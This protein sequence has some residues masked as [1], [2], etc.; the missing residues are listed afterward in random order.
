MV[1]CRCVFHAAATPHSSIVFCRS[2]SRRR[3]RLLL[4]ALDFVLGLLVFLRAGYTTLEHFALVKIE[5]KSASIRFHY[6]AIRS[7]I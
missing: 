6:L 1:T 3:T 4:I 7:Y 5:N 2:L